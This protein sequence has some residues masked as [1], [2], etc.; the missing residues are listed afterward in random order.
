MQYDMQYRRGNA[1]GIILVSRKN[2]AARPRTIAIHVLFS[3]RERSLGRMG[4]GEHASNCYKRN[5]HSRTLLNSCA[6]RTGYA[7]SKWDCIRHT[8]SGSRHPVLLRPILQRSLEVW[9]IRLRL[10]TAVLFSTV[11]SLA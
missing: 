1:E 2:R 10:A 6:K 7:R 5:R 8:E 3:V 11:G 4:G 9:S